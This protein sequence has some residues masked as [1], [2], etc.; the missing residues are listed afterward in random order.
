MLVQLNKWVVVCC[1][2]LQRGHIG[3]GCR[4]FCLNI[5][6]DGDIVCSEFGHGTTGCS[7][8]VVLE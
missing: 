6:I 3:D 7:G 2:D 4:Q 8:S 5:R 1:C